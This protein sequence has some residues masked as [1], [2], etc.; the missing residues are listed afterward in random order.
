M[1]TIGGFDAIRNTKIRLKVSDATGVGTFRGVLKRFEQDGGSIDETW[2]PDQLKQGVS[3]VLND[4]HGF[5]VVI[6]PVAQ[7]E[8]ASMTVTISAD[9]PPHE[10]TQTVDVSDNEPFGWRVFME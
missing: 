6:L 8:T 4:A 10:E 5:N 2:S 7:K 1:I 9:D 3:A